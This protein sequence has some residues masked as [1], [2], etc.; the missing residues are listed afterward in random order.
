MVLYAGG[1]LG[2]MFGLWMFRCFCQYVIQL[3]LPEVKDDV[4]IFF[5]V[6]YENWGLYKNRLLKKPGFCFAK[7]SKNRFLKPF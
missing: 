2:S 3:V 6:G 1:A 5:N 4:C 7:F